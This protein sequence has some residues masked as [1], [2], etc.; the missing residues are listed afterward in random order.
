[1]NI[2]P[3]IILKPE[4]TKRIR[5]KSQGDQL[6]TTNTEEVVLVVKSMP[7]S[8]GDEGQVWSLDQEDS[9]EEG[10]VIHFSILAW[11][12]PWTAEPGRLYSMGSQILGHDWS[13][14]VRTHCPV[15]LPHDIYF[16][17]KQWET[18]IKPNSS[19]ATSKRYVPE[20]RLYTTSEWR[21]TPKTPSDSSPHS[22]H[23][24]FSKGLHLKVN[25]CRTKIGNC[26]SEHGIHRSLVSVLLDPRLASEICCLRGNRPSTDEYLTPL[27]V[28]FAKLDTQIFKLLNSLI[29]PFYVINTS[30]CNF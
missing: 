16:P 13:N 19:S 3:E 29:S 22:V 25:K 5:D 4:E 12:I 2:I 18:Q 17:C 28:L 10:M 26:I 7:A 6:V 11:R 27:T 8:V 24:H 15:Q 23:S 20:P 9:L 21:T 30:E 14:L 1:M